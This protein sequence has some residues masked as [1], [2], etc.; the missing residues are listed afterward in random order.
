MSHRRVPRRTVCRTLV[1]GAASAGLAGCLGGS[2]D[3][4]S[5][6]REVPAEINFGNI[7][8]NPAFPFKLL[9]PDSRACVTEVQYHD[10]ASSINTHWHFEPLTV[11]HELEYTLVVAVLNLEQEPVPLG[12]SESLQVGARF[13]N[14][15]SSQSLTVSV[16]GETITFS[17]QTRDTAEVIF[18]I[19]QDD[20]TLWSTPMLSVKVVDESQLENKCTPGELPER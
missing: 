5:E 13:A 11:P 2:D 8:L 19:E 18:D 17:G 20:E 4:E 15:S 9:V 3:T 12:E 1:T 7:K 10:E 14:E 16:E 6:P